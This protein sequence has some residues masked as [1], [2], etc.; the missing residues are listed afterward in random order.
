MSSLHLFLRSRR[1]SSL[2]IG[3][4]TGAKSS[5][6]LLRAP[7]THRVTP[8]TMSM[9]RIPAPN[10]DVRYLARRGRELKALIID[11]AASTSRYARYWW[12]NRREILIQVKNHPP[13]THSRTPSRGQSQFAERAGS[14]LHAFP[15]SIVLRGLSARAQVCER[16]LFSRSLLRGFS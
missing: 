8:F 11:L 7:I 4:E 15:S 1:V 13:N 16:A 9:A 6:L 12:R 10:Q 3:G 14:G 5:E 2:D